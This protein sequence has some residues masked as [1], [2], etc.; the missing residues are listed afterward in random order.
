M[1]LK[2]GMEKAVKAVTK[3]LEKMQQKNPRPNKRS[4]KWQRFPPMATK[5]LAK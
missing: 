2:R 5:K 1:D 3:E 4:R